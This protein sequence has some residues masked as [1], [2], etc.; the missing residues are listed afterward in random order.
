MDPPEK[1]RISIIASAGSTG[2][3][4]YIGALARLFEAT[5]KGELPEPYHMAGA[6]G[7]ALA[8]AS[9]LPWE[10]K[11]FSKAL[12]ITSTLGP[13]KIS[14][15]SSFLKSR[16][17]GIAIIKI[18]NHFFPEMI[19]NI[20]KK[21]FKRSDYERF[22][23]LFKTGELILDAALTSLLI[24]EIFSMPSLFSSKPLL[25][26]LADN[27]DLRGIFNSKIKLDVIS[28]DRKSG[29]QIVFTNYLPEHKNIDKS[30]RNRFFLKG[31]LSSASLPGFFPPVIEGDMELV[32]GG[33]ITTVPINRAININ[34]SPDVILLLLYK[35]LEDRSN[36]NHGVSAIENLHD[37]Y[38]ITGHEAARKN[39]ETFMDINDNLV[40]LRE[41]LEHEKRDNR[42]QEELNKFDSIINKFS[43][44][45]KKHIP[46]VI[47]QPEEEVPNIGFSEFNKKDLMISMD[48]GHTTMGK[49]IPRIKEALNN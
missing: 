35:H 24:Y 27:L 32:D 21:V 23:Y 36:G 6:S 16:L 29:K 3:P 15:Y 28:V 46:L 25:N 1:K 10:Q 30:I 8:L 12:E 22:Y 4:Y 44:A 18:V 17:G 7:S 42:T 19:K 31:L 41:L 20:F 38:L 47:V 34:P 13:E 11:T 26:L 45:D 37:C 49:A 43:F 33:V 9:V 14:G 40:V 2:Y 48:I 39:V 5:D